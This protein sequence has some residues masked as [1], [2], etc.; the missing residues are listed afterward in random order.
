MI[1]ALLLLA[2]TKDTPDDTA[3]PLV[4]PE[5]AHTAGDAVLEG[6]AIVVE[7]SAVDDDGVGGASMLYRPKDGPYWSS[8][9]LVA[10][11]DGETWVGEIPAADVVA[12][13][14][15]YT[16]KAVDLGDPEAASFLP[17]DDDAFEVEVLVV[18]L[19][20]PFS[21]DF[22]LRD[23]AAD[24]FG[25]G[26]AQD[27]LEFQGYPW[28]LTTGFAFDG[29]QSVG[30]LRGADSGQVVDDWL[31]SPALDFS[32]QDRVGV[33]WQELGNNA[34]LGTHTL[35]VSTGSRIPADDDFEL[36][37]ELPNAL[38]DAWDRSPVVDLSAYAGERAVYVAWRYQGS[39]SDDWFIDAVSVQELVV[40]VDASLRV[41]TSP[42][43]PGDTV[44]LNVD[45]VNTVD[46]AG[47]PVTVTA[48]LPSGG[49]SI[50]VD[51]V[52]VAEMGALGTDTAQFDLT[53]DGSW[54]D[55]SYLPVQFTI[56]TPT[57]SWILS[58]QV[59]I[60]EQSWAS[61]EL[62]I[63]LPALVQVELGVGDPDAPEWSQ[64]V[65]A[66]T[67]SGGPL[68]IDVDLTDQHA[69][70]PPGPGLDR[71]WARIDA[72]TEGTVDAFS[73]L[74]DGVAYDA[75]VLPPLYAGETALVY[76]PQPPDLRAE[77]QSQSPSQVAPGDQ[78]TLD[79]VLANRGSATAGPVTATLVTD[80]GDVSVVTAEL[81]TLTAG[82]W[83]ADETVLVEDL[84]LDVS[85][86]HVDSTAVSARIE[87]DDGV[88]QWSVPLS[89]D[90]PW[91]VFRITGV[92]I[93]DD[94]GSGTLEPGESADLEIDLTNV[95]DLDPASLVVGTLTLAS[96]STATATIDDDTATFGSVSAGST[97]TKDFTVSVD[98]GS[99]LGETLDLV[100]DL[101]DGTN[102]YQAQ[103]QVVL[104][105]LPWLS[106]SSLDDTLGDG[107]GDAIDIRNVQYRSDGT[108]VELLLESYTDFDA[109]AVY[110]EMW[111]VAL[112]G[113]Y[114]FYRVSTVSGLATLQGYDGG[115]T[116]LNRPTL[117]QP[118]TNQLLLSWTAADMGLS[119]TTLSVG[120]GSG[121]CFSS[122]GSFCD[123]FPDG[124]GYYYD[125]TY[126]PSDFYSLSW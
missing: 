81:G 74:T 75:T 90:V 77:G 124:W 61:L 27:A 115:F 105:E 70:L 86:G 126:N 111:A 84:M 65:Y 107:N 41:D 67:W 6:N 69:L 25:L 14:M 108:T 76:V 22:E 26:W 83:G 116:T 47:G 103:V 63:T 23:G 32:G 62:G 102:S 112:S 114:T 58:D 8:V 89:V 100:L 9:E 80:D 110:F 64:S 95:G 97:K 96:S 72:G 49:G 44:V 66:E 43:D 119:L 33:T 29:E 50:A 93:D 113:D 73:I 40:D 36:I 104:G 51:Q 101:S 20:L 98:A 123:H 91:P 117:S 92:E 109:N 87:L 54:P 1:A 120:F 18:G 59:L 88:E 12:P 106:I 13:A 38:E 42:V 15:E 31:L 39:Y 19:A 99:S 85:I 45:L 10:S 46:L 37:A 56:A 2:C 94:D 60:G 4:G 79:V 28:G 3:P 34:D 52:E 82:P 53:V 68:I 55:N 121:S 57:D 30:H 24:I 118:A 5:L 122:T 78:V 16:F 17:E 125:G 11:D 71:W 7:L 21:E 35:W 48:A